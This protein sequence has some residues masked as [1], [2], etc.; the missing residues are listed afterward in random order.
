MSEKPQPTERW[1]GNLNVPRPRQKVPRGR[2]FYLLLALAFFAGLL[3][4]GG[5]WA[6][7]EFAHRPRVF[8]YGA[9]VISLGCLVI[10]VLITVPDEPKAVFHPRFWT[11]G[12]APLTLVRTGLALL[13]FG[14]PSLVALV[15]LIVAG[16]QAG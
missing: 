8:S 14:L 1:Q 12:P 7:S 2:A 16:L 10:A 11:P 5:L 3:V 9:T 15:V 4:I 6:W 13:A